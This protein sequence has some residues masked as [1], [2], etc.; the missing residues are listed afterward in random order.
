MDPWS[1]NK[2][3]IAEQ[4]LNKELQRK[5]KDLELENAV[6]KSLLKKTY[7]LWNSEKPLF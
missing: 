3:K 7:P 5:L 1:K 2:D 6:L 4:K